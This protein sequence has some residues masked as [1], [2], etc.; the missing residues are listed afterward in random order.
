MRH[1]CAVRI[2]ENPC[3]PT[4]IWRGLLMLVLN[5]PFASCIP[6]QAKGPVTRPPKPALLRPRHLRPRWRGGRLLLLLAQRVEHAAAVPRRSAGHLLG[7]GAR[8]QDDRG[9]LAV[10]AGQDR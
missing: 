8:V 1:P 2:S 6:S 9:R 7:R 5:L 4:E 3:D 10:P